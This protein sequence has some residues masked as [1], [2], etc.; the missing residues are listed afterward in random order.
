MQVKAAERKARLQV[1]SQIHESVA[2]YDPGRRQD[3]P[4]IPADAHPGLRH[5]LRSLTG[6]LLV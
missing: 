1:G 3:P 6:R 4:P 2:I 5:R